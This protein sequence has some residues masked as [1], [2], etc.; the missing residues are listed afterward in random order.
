MSHRPHPFGWGQAAATTLELL[1]GLSGVPPESPSRMHGQPS[2]QELARAALP[3]AATATGFL[4]ALPR[5]VRR[6]K[7]DDP[8]VGRDGERA[9]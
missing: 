2:M 9:Q 3:P 4:L 8:G 7:G 6:G 5:A 1:A